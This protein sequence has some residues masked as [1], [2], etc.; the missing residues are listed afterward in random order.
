MISWMEDDPYRFCHDLERGVVKVLD[1]K[2]L[3]TFIQQIRAKFESAPTQVDKEKRF[4][5]YERRRWG[6][7]LKTLLAAQR[8]VDA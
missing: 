5:S 7:V 8:N 1:K 6:G 2:G 4:S 3:A